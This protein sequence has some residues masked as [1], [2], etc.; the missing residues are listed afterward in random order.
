MTDDARRAQ[1]EQLLTEEAYQ[2][3]W[4][5]ACRMCTAAGRVQTA[6]AEDL[7]QES[8]VHALLKLQQLREPARFTGWL[9]SIVRTRFISRHRGRAPAAVALDDAPPLAAAEHAGDPLVTEML[10][11]LASLP[12]AQ[13]RLL[14]LFY[15]DGLSL[16][17]TGQALGIAPR[18]VR[19]RLH[20]ARA[21]LR[22]Q[23]AAPAT[24]IRISPGS[25]EGVIQ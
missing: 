21:A 16:K 15:M 1:F 6:D 3:A 4:R 13:Q 8:L 17:E 5:H 20:R 11:A 23:L 10:A 14:E 12:K 19:Q 25:T 24:S 18:V 2:A 22:K 9:L 7:L